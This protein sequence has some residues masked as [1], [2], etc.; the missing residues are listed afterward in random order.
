MVSFLRDPL[1]ASLPG[2]AVLQ[3]FDMRTPHHIASLDGLR[4]IAAFLVVIS[5]VA[6]L[7]PHLPAGFTLNI[8][9]EAVE[10]FFALSGF[11]MASLYAA[12]PLDRDAALD[13]LVHRFARIYPVYLVAVAF[14]VFLS[15]V[16]GLDYIHAITGPVEILRHVAMLGSSGVFWSV[17]PE[18]QFYFFFLLVWLCLSNPRRF[19]MLA[20]ILALCV[21]VDI[22]Y[23]FPGPGILLPSKVHFFL[24]GVGAGLLYASGRWR[25][26]G[27]P[28]GI[29]AL[30]LLG[31]VFL[32]KMLMWRD[33]TDGWGLGMALT[34][35]AI[36]FLTALEHP[37][38]RAVLASRPL[39]FLGRI[40]FSLY[41]F[42]L[43]VMFLSMKT[44]TE[45]LPGGIAILAAVGLAVL[46]ATFTY[47]LIEDPARRV[48]VTAWKGRAAGPA[49]RARA[50][51]GQGLAPTA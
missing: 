6:L 38:S 13:Y 31:F 27:W 17:S 18:I 28:V 44:L 51:H 19:R 12:R 5:H 16:P 11:L 1:P 26:S 47:H 29:A 3:D 37:L 50:G 24:A 14:V 46:F 2:R 34:A 49:R 23:G 15:R 8:G 41:L 39:R 7:Y 20:A 43:P 32:S 10:I 36:V 25:P 30:G 40:S 33:Q 48:L 22:D 35:G 9:A 42:H 21:I 4:G 45:F